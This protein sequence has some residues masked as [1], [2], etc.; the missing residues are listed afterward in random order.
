MLPELCQ[1]LNFSSYQKTSGRLRNILQIILAWVCN[2]LLCG[3]F[4]V[5]NFTLESNPLKEC[6]S[7]IYTLVEGNCKMMSRRIAQKA[8]R[9]GSGDTRAE[10]A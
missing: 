9:T 5:S 1:Y 4:L 10:Y 3:Y 8:E 2:I 7:G 6:S